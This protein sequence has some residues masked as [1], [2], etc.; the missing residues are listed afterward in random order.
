[1]SALMDV[2]NYII[3]E[4]PFYG[5]YTNI[6]EVDIRLFGVSLYICNFL[7]DFNCFLFKS[8]GCRHYLQERPVTSGNYLLML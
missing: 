5:Y 4:V 6:T 2:H 7:L 3:T 1:M 8:D